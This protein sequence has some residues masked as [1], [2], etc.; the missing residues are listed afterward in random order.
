MSAATVSEHDPVMSSQPIGSRTDAAR[1]S[2]ERTTSTS[3]EERATESFFAFVTSVFQGWRAHGIAFLVLRNYDS[4]PISTSNDIDVLV[5]REQFRQAE[6]VM[7]IAAAQA[8][9][10]LHN[11]VRFATTA[12]FFYH[13]PTHRQI[14]V[15][16]FS[17]L[18][19][20]SLPLL[21]PEDVVAARLHRGLYDIP[22]PV[23]E[24]LISLLTSIVYAG[25]VKERYKA[26][27]LAGLRSVPDLAGRL[28]ADAVGV[29]LARECVERSLAEQWTAVE[30]LCGDL[31]R[32]LIR[33]QMTRHPWMTLRAVVG[34]LVRLLGRLVQPPGLR[35]VLVSADRSVAASVG[36]RLVQ[37]LRDTFNPGRGVRASG[38]DAHPLAGTGPVVSRG[39]R[40]VQSGVGFDVRARLALF[41]IGLVLI[42]DDDGRSTDGRGQD[43]LQTN[44]RRRLRRLA[45]GA[46]CLLLLDGVTEDTT[47]GKSGTFHA[48]R[49]E[50]W[51]REMAAFPHAVVLDANEPPEQAAFKATA[52]VLQTMARRASRRGR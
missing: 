41:R 23:H 46:D 29:A 5:R 3:I 39:G 15:D 12:C 51:R 9:Y 1:P 38:G 21:P 47:G 32:A 2:S 6:R 31:R 40:S 37:H 4:L 44:A 17:S 25:Q 52:H 27:I 11:R 16:L 36:D 8:G 18:R 22:S 13:P 45:R 7:V 50:S 28:L 49:A 33:R 20:H 34:D 10:V 14:H 35:V 42:E 24:A 26:A 30:A 19:W 48:S 43:S